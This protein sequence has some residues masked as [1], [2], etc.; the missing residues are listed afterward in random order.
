MQSI[1]KAQ[2]DKWLGNRKSSLIAKFWSEGNGCQIVLKD[3]LICKKYDT[4]GIFL[5]FEESVA[6]NK[7]SLLDFFSDIEKE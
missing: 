3:R 1:S 6:D 4:N 5:S 7:D 2:I